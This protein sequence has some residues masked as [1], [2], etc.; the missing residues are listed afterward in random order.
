MSP[1]AGPSAH[2]ITFP[3][4]WEDGDTGTLIIDAD[5][6]YVFPKDINA[7]A[8]LIQPPLYRR[9]YLWLWARWWL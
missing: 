7:L 3:V 9:A 4:H 2:R 1:P 6:R 8:E 5:G